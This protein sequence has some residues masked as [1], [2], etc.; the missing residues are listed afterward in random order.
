M[1][2]NRIAPTLRGKAA[3]AGATAAVALAIGTLI[4]PWEGVKY[5]AYLDRLAR[6]PVWTICAG[7]TANVKPGM[8]ETPE[9]CDKRLSDRINR[10]FLPGLRACIKDFDD[11]PISWQAAMLSL[12]WNLGVRRT[13]GSQAA[14]FA[15]AGEIKNSC[16]AMTAFNQAGGKIVPGLV[17]RRE[18]GDGTRIGEAELCVS[19]LS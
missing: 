5:H 17:K 10:E 4:V 19:G 13:C 1:P 14:Q 6:P 3:L 7:D 9:G 8:V 16:L 15:R 11:K 2:L 12:A 18:T